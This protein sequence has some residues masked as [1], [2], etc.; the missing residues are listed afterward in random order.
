MLLHVLARAQSSHSNINNHVNNIH[1]HSLPSG[2]CIQSGVQS[3]PFAPPWLRACSSSH[4]RSRQGPFSLMGGQG[5]RQQTLFSHP[6]TSEA[7]LPPWHVA[8]TL[9]PPVA[10]FLTW[11]VSYQCLKNENTFFCVRSFWRGHD[12]RQLSQATHYYRGCSSTHV[13]V[14]TYVRVRCPL[15]CVV[16]VRVNL[17]MHIYIHLYQALIRH[18]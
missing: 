11:E 1:R 16:S 18:I 8:E 4:S 9:P 3:H 6:G 5:P 14:Y 10:R 12:L 15:Y 2:P 7:L 17:R 13:H